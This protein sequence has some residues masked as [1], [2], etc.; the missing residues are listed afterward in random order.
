MNR[1]VIPEEL[2]ARVLQMHRATSEKGFQTTLIQE[3]RLLG[4]VANHTQTST[5]YDARSGRVTHL[6]DQ[7]G[8]LGFPDVIIL[9]PGRY[10]FALELKRTR[11]ADN[12]TPEQEKW[13]RSFRS[14]G[15][16]SA[17]MTPFDTETCRALLRQPDLCD[18]WILDP[19]GPIQSDLTMLYKPKSRK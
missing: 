16:R 12:Y 8:D 5:R 4:C 18:P 19:N 3:A 9:K 10:V 13:V 17:I 7:I 1:Y 11:E 6:T 15:V 14:I 2:P